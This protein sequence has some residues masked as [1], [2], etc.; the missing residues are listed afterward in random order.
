MC[1]LCISNP[2]VAVKGLNIPNT[3]GNSD[4]APNFANFMDQRKL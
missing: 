3:N 2:T 4:L 1:K